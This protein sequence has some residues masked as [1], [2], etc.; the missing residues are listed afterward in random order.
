MILKL[1]YL[2]DRK[3]LQGTTLLEAL[4]EGYELSSGFSFKIE[5]PILSNTIEVSTSVCPHSAVL[6][7]LQTSLYIT[8]KET[9]PPIIREAFD[10]TAITERMW[11]EDGVVVPHIA[12]ISPVKTMVAAFKA[13]LLSSYPVPHKPGHWV[14]I[15]LDS[16]CPM[17]ATYSLMSLKNIYCRGGLAKCNIFLDTEARA[18]LYFAWANI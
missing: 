7:F 5:K 1:P 13:K 2:G 11:E 14:F 18:T 4:L 12:G 9:T 3:Y 16:Q 6:T 15:R 8:E 10:E 17:A